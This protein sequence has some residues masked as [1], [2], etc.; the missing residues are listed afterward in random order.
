MLVIRKEQI[1]V[2]SAAMRQRFI[3]R[4]VSHLN[5]VFPDKLIEMESI[6][7]DDDNQSLEA[8]IT[9]LITTAEE[10]DILTE[11]DVARYIS[12]VTEFGEG[13]DKDRNMRWATNILANR[14][15]SGTTRI[16]LLYEHLTIKFPDSRIALPPGRNTEQ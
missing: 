14:K 16:S 2:L 8:Y 11:G 10:I 1:E 4:M 15:L 6:Q 12:F 9:N 7:A 5:T 13:F 3:D